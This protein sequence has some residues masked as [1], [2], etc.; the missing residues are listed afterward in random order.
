MANKSNF[1]VTLIYQVLLSL[2]LAF[3]LITLGRV[4]F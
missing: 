4:S 1:K 2:A 3:L